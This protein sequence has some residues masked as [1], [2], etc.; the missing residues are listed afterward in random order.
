MSPPSAIKPSPVLLTPEQASAPLVWSQPPI[1]DSVLPGREH[2]ETGR[3]VSDFLA[4]WKIWSERPMPAIDRARA[5]FGQTMSNQTDLSS[6]QIHDVLERVTPAPGADRSERGEVGMASWVEM[7]GRRFLNRSQRWFPVW[8]GYVAWV[9]DW[10]RSRDYSTIVFLCRDSLPFYALARAFVA[11]DEDAPELALVHLTR[12]TMS[13]HRIADHISDALG[14]AES[15]AFVDTGCYGTV[16]P[17]LVDACR[18]HDVPPAVFFY[19][20]RSPLIFGYMN[21]LM[22]FDM[23]NAP[24]D[25]ATPGSSPAD[26][27]IYAGDV[28]EAQPKSYHILSM[29]DHG[30]PHVAPADAISFALS[31]Q[32]LRVL[33]Q[34]AASRRMSSGFLQKDAREAALDRYRAFA[35]LE[36]TGARAANQLFDSP[37]PKTPGAARAAAALPLE[38]LP[39]QGEFFGISPG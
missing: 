36:D 20:S 3:H 24:K 7:C 9:L 16:V 5:E 10:C 15:I 39:P 26:F 19:F 13:D 34:F 30:I 29:T 11:E 37:A 8:L 2:W 21:Y 4:E 25:G 31:G 6:A 1:V 35:L 27:A 14:D 22:A 33:T 38:G 12:R 23:L 17:Q 18:R 28:V 32:L